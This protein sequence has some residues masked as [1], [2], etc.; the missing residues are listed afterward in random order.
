M[1]NDEETNQVLFKLQRLTPPYVGSSRAS[2]FSAIAGRIRF[3]RHT[4]GLVDMKCMQNHRAIV[5]LE[6]AYQN[7]D[8]FVY[9]PQHDHCKCVDARPSAAFD[10]S[11]TFA[12]PLLEET[13]VSGTLAARINTLEAA[14]R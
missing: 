8:N 5:P 2:M 12:L 3:V 11:V 14:A 1:N 13:V 6:N 9:M 10:K 4:R 7:S